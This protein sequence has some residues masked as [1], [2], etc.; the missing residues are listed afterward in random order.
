[1]NELLLRD[2]INQITGMLNAVER[3]MPD[4]AEIL[5]QLSTLRLSLGQFCL[6][7]SKLT[8]INFDLL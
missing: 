7:L 1:M 3:N 4:T 8:G 5:I 6:A 2:N